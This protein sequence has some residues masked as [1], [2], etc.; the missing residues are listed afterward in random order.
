MPDIVIPEFMDEDAIRDGLAGFDV[1]Y[2][3]GLVDRPDELAAALAS[4]RALIVRNRTQVRGR[5]LEAGRRLEAVGRLGVGLDNIDLETCR[6][7]G[8]AVYPARGAND[9]SVAEYV[10]TAAL[11]LLRGAWFATGDVLAGAWPRE[12]LIGRELSGCRLGLLG[13]GSNARQTANRA[14]ALGMAVSAYDPH[15]PADDPAWTGGFAPVRSVSLD[16]VLTWSDVVSVHVPL[17]P[18]TRGLIGAAA[19]ARM[20]PDAIII[21]A[22]RGGIV[23]EAALAEALRA[24]RLG[25]AA[26]DVFA[27]EPLSAEAARLFAGVPNLILTPHIA[28]V[29]EQANGRVSRV[30]AD[31]IRRHLSERPRGQGI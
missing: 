10:I 20:K 30:T 19:L 1:R 2:D 4:A 9:I 8:I 13:F 29:T 17:T 24:G 22:A 16:E 14:A 21:N 26:L 15:L 12:N 25:G 7:R 11:V 18:E 27:S 5:L 3:P 28:G 6:N 23:D 31:S